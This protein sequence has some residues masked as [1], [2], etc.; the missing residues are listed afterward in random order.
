MR[1]ADANI[2][3]Y[4]ALVRWNHPQ[5]GVLLPVQFLRVAEDSGQ[6][7]AIDWQMYRMACAAGHDLV[8][9]GETGVLVAPGDDAALANV[10]ASLAADPAL[11]DALGA[12]AAGDLTDR[13][14]AH[15]LLD[16]VQSLYDTLL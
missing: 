1:L 11:R 9:D 3:G 16:D 6:I 15:R 5:R 14:A 12:A 8:R 4:E 2:V 10:L 13:F 7:E